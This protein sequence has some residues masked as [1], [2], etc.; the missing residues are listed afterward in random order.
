LIPPADVPDSGSSPS[1]PSGAGHPGAEPVD[2]YVRLGVTPDAPFDQVK[3]ARDARIAEIGDDDPLARSRVEAAYDA[4]L[5]DRLKERQQGRVSTAARS[6][7][8]REQVAPPAERVSL[9]SLPRLAPLPLVRNAARP[10]FALPQLE[11]ATGRERWFPL[12]AIGAL[13]VFL[14]LPGTDP[15]LPLALGALAALVNLQR[16]HG[17]FLQAVIT[18]LALL[19][20]GL[21]VGAALVALLGSQLDGLPLAPLQLESVPALLLLL[22]GALLLA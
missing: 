18:T 14:L 20:V 3:E 15:G 21:L 6:A 5:M 2:P 17:R 4:V 10:S 12:V 16:R 9:P 8:Q 22:A 13:L 11:L 7:S 19:V 1:D